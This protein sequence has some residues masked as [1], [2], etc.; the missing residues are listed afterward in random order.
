MKAK[1]MEAKESIIILQKEY[2]KKVGECDYYKEQYELQ[3]QAL[4]KIEVEVR[5]EF[6]DEGAI[7]K[8][9]KSLKKKI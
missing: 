9:K 3:L 6:T 5:A 8:S 7:R 4:A 1:E 2:N